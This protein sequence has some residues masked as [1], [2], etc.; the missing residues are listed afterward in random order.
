MKWGFGYRLCKCGHIRDAHRHYRPGADCGLCD[1]PRWSRQGW[2]GSSRT[3]R[4]ARRQVEDLQ[5]EIP[6]DTQ[7]D[8]QPKPPQ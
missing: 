6:W 7:Q 2:L 8:L 5:S 3:R 1:C 4:M